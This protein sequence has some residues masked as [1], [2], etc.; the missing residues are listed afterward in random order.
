MKQILGL[1]LC[2]G[3]SLPIL[4]QSDAKSKAILDKVSKVTKTYKTIKLS[5]SL[6]IASPGNNPINQKG[7]AYLKGDKYF[8]DMP[9]QSIFCNGTRVWTL[10][11]DDNECYVADVD[12]DDEDFI[13]P[14]KLLT[15]WE[16]GFTFKYSKEMTYKGK[17]VHEIYLYPN[18]AKSSKYH[19]IIL[20]IDKATNQVVHVHI[21]GKDGTHMK[22]SLSSF[23]K[24]ITIPDSQFEFNKAKHPGVTIIEE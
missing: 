6:S 20:K 3:F 18:D 1:I 17:S 14:S 10:I 23:E 9:D 15:I 13:K 8:I 5:Y 4:A 22:Y 11:K 2:I 19:T 16:K 12:E 7:E 24:N 21:K